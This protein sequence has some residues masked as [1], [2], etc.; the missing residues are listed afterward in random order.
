[1]FREDKTFTLRVS[2]EATFPDDYD[3]DDDQYQWLREWD[4]AI[5]GEVLK[6]VFAALRRYPGWTARVRNRGMSEQDE[7]EIV[8]SWNSGSEPTLWGQP[9]HETSR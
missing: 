3:G 8:L 2:L 9:E 6:A 1:M 7:I 5:K 4:G